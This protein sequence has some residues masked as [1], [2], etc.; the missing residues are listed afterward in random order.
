M[1]AVRSVWTVQDF[2][3]S[4]DSVQAVRLVRSR[5]PQQMGQRLGQPQRPANDHSLPVW[6]TSL[7]HVSRDDKTPEEHVARTRAWKADLRSTPEG[8]AEYQEMC[9]KAID[10][11][12]RLATRRSA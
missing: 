6:S 7:G 12:Q 11:A 9:A 1:Q 8:E 5:R 2:P 4:H 3:G 10:T